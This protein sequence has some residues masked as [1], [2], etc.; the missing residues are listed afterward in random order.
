MLLWYLKDRNGVADATGTRKMNEE[1][2]NIKLV[3]MM[4]GLAL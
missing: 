1:S 4:V 2:L 3:E